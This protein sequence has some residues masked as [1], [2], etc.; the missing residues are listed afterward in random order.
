MNRSEIIS[1]FQEENPEITTR[2]VTAAVLQ[3]WVK[4]G[5]LEFAC[6]ARMIS[7]VTTFSA[8]IGIDEYDLMDQIT[9][10]YDIDELPGGGVAYDDKRVR[11]TTRAE[12]DR[13]T[14]SWRSNSNGT[15][16]KYYRRNQYIYFERPPDAT[17]DITIDAIIKPD[18]FDDDAKTPFNELTYLESFHYGLVLYLKMRAKGKV[19][20]LEEFKAAYAEYDTYQKATKKI[21]QGGKLSKIS[22]TPS[23]HFPSS[24]YR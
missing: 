16:R 17:D 14:S 7:S 10:F 20:K 24:M 8:V 15:P 4:V 11:H 21:I 2:V 23:Q 18:A 3:E 12:L 19:G 13:K 9:N 6:G 1:R 5:N 22:I